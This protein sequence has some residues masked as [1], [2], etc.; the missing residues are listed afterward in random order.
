M[1]VCNYNKIIILYMDDPE[2]CV[3]FSTNLEILKI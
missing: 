3:G 2:K 1:S